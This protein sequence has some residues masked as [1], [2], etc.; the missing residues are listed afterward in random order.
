MKAGGAVSA[1]GLAVPSLLVPGLLAL[2]LVAWGL[3]SGRA[4]RLLPGQEAALAVAL[5]ALAGLGRPGWRRAGGALIV[6]A[7][8][9]GWIAGGAP[10]PAGPWLRGDPQ[11][12]AALA[13]MG[14]VA[15]IGP[16]VPRPARARFALTLGFGALALLAA[17]PLPAWLGLAGMA[18]LGAGRR[19]VAL[20]LAGYGLAPALF[21]IA[22][23]GRAGAVFLVIGLG[24]LAVLPLARPWQAGSAGP[25]GPAR[26]LAG[27]VLPLAALLRLH[28]LLP[29]GSAAAAGLGLALLLAGA[30]S[31]WSARNGAGRVGAAAAA[32]NAVALFGFGLAGRAPHLGAF[33]ILAGAA[34]LAASLARGAATRPGWLGPL[35]RAA[36]VGLPPFAPF[37][38]MM[39]IATAAAARGGGL[40]LPL[41][42]G[43]GLGALGLLRA[44]R[45]PAVAAGRA[46]GLALA[47]ALAVA[48][49]GGVL[50]P[51]AP[52]GLAA[53]LAGIAR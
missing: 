40:V 1:D 5:V 7:S 26:A 12:L 37:A 30:G 45:R 18:V 21:G 28:A 6:A 19:R 43:I 47:A 39:L 52:P 14:L 33:L 35:G 9:L 29:G 17:A 20:A 36:L 41:A 23:G 11:T 34:P 38:G 16:P 24:W 13:V 3:L 31:V 32:M 27:R 46:G 10:L 51:L 2:S 8:L 25:A 48:L 42:L 44:E 22:L 15:L 53:A 4:L 50:L 49:A